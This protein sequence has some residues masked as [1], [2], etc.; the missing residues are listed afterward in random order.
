MTSMGDSDWFMRKW[1][2]KGCWVSRASL[3]TSGGQGPRRGVR[4][5]LSNRTG[6]GKMAA[7]W[8]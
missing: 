8:Y 5:V 7:P 2:R 1:G 6:K 4:D 3:A